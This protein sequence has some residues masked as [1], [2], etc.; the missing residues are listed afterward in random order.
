MKPCI[1]FACSGRA[2]IF[3]I[4][5]NA[6][7]SSSINLFIYSRQKDSPK[8]LRIIKTEPLFLYRAVTAG[9]VNRIANL[10]KLRKTEQFNLL[11]LYQ[12]SHKHNTIKRNLNLLYFP[13]LYIIKE[14][15]KL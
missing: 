5:V 6:A 3:G 13:L 4:G 10:R 7:K 14:N 2:A 1:I 9:R 11:Q 8:K 15:I 12:A